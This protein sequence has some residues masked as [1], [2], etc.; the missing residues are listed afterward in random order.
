MRINLANAAGQPANYVIPFAPD[1]GDGGL[2]YQLQSV[3]IDYASAVNA[4]LV[5]QV[6][7]SDGVV[8]FESGMSAAILGAV[9]LSVTWSNI[10]FQYQTATHVYLPLP[11]LFVETDDI[12][13]VTDLVAPIDP[14]VGVIDLI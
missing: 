2:V 10:G 12:I 6:I 5:L 4:D 9:N 3:H 13:R 1:S 11:P 8:V 7:D 14:I